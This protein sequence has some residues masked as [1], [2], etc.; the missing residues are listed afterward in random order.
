M[1]MLIC[2]LTY[3]F[4]YVCMLAVCMEFIFRYV[5]CIQ[6]NFSGKKSNAFYNKNRH[7]NIHIYIYMV[8][9]SNVWRI[10]ITSAFIF[11]STV[12]KNSSV[13]Q[14]TAPMTKIYLFCHSVVVTRHAS[15]HIL[16]FIIILVYCVRVLSS[17]CLELIT[18]W[19]NKT[20]RFHPHL[21]SVLCKN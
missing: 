6:L 5:F 13:N 17:M 2:M 20:L 4:V 14:W 8:Y 7:T 18:T 11:I 21:E 19:L 12:K 1:Y 16:P 9:T 3:A 15:L 10:R